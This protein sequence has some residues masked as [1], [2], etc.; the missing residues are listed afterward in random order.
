PITFFSRAQPTSSPDRLPHRPVAHV[1][2]TRHHLTRAVAH[3]HLILARRQRETGLGGSLHVA[4]VPSRDVPRPQV[5]ARAVHRLHAR[6]EGG[7]WVAEADRP[8]RVHPL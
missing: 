6:P 4:A 3:T 2:L 7:T 1:N 5:L 8:R